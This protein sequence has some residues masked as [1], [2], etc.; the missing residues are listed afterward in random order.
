MRSLI[1]PCE[2]RL[3]EFDAKLLLALAASRRGVQAIVGAKKSID[4]NLARY[5][6]GVYVGK[7]LTERSRHNLEMARRC[8][9]R[10]ALWD[11]EGLVWASREVYWRTKLDPRTLAAPQRLLAWGRENAD[12]W[13]DHPDYADTPIDITGN[14][15]GDL[16][17][18]ELRGHFAA[19]V[20]GIRK[21]HGRFLLI[22]TNFSRVNH[23]QPQQNRHLRWLREQRP[24]DPRGGFAAHKYALFN[25]F[26]TMVPELARA[27]P[28][29]RIVIR[30][31]PSER[32]ATWE[33]LTADFEN[34]SVNPGDNAIAW[35]LAA[36]GLIHNGCTTA[37]EGYLMERPALA[38]MPVRS[39][40]F[41]HPLPNGLSRQIDSLDELIEE[42]QR[43]Q[44]NPEAYFAALATPD[45]QELL[46]RNLTGL[47]GTPMACERVLDALQP[48]LADSS[49]PERA[50]PDMAR[51]LLAL[52][53]AWRLVELRIPGQANYGPY[54]RHM[55]PPTSLS[56]VQQRIVTLASGLEMDTLP[57]LE[58]LQPDVFSVHPAT[59]G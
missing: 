7:S 3:R 46:A 32:I 38:Y 45:R 25:A 41:D 50:A 58:Q 31:H 1:L 10:V 8:G 13:H 17:R 52:R 21:R 56:E 2:T 44:E 51:M 37:L 12:I 22:N 15:R 30:P 36:D 20:A 49:P 43:C 4:L 27:L 39:S 26:T 57:R 9:H 29:T 19:A 18:P 14:P 28:D 59:A 34:V 54:L 47:P 11:E 5:P 53:R 55:F 24:N 16:L 35:L 33:D 42:A 6:D 40:Q 23:V 48:L